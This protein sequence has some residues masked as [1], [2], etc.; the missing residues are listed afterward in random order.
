MTRA[1]ILAELATMAEGAHRICITTAF[2]RR[3]EILL[4]S[5]PEGYGQHSSYNS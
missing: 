3:M 1:D 4:P 2:E 5:Y